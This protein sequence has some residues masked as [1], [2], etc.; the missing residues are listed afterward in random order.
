MIPAAVVG[1]AALVSVGQD[2]VI[3]ESSEVAVSWGLE[4]RLEEELE[5]AVQVLADDRGLVDPGDV[6]EWIRER[7]RLFNFCEAVRVGLVVDAGDAPAGF[8]IEDRVRVAVESRLRAARLFATSEGPLL[9]FQVHVLGLEVGRSAVFSVR[10][11]FAKTVADTATGIP[12][13]AAVWEAPPYLGVSLN[14]EDVVSAVSGRLD[15]FVAEYLRVNESA[16]GGPG[17]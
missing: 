6:A 7:F 11:F 15:H 14:P 8:E 3:D 4:E 17:R 12:E 9:V 2:P 16:C 13:L 10:L 5:L 1:V